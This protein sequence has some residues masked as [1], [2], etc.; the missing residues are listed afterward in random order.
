MSLLFIN[1]KAAEIN[2]S[3]YQDFCRY[4]DLKEE[5]DVKVAKEALIR[6]Q[7]RLDIFD[8]LNKQELKQMTWLLGPAVD[9]NQKKNEVF[10]KKEKEYR[11]NQ[12]GAERDNK[13]STY[14]QYYIDTVVLDPWHFMLYW[15][16]VFDPHLLGFYFSF[17]VTGDNEFEC[18]SIYCERPNSV[19]GDKLTEY[20]DLFNHLKKLFL[21]FN[22]NLWKR[23]NQQNPAAVAPNFDQS[24]GMRL[25]FYNRD[26]LIYFIIEITNHLIAYCYMSRNRQ[27]NTIIR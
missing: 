7:D 21:S 11:Q 12:N 9:L 18:V 5:R 25:K 27:S 6:V 16:S 15:R 14:N 23:V 26:S 2:P 1:D 10:A 20:N 22:Q 17:Q 24:K 4:H 13:K 3:K 8:R 19:D